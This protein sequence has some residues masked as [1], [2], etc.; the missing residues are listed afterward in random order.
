MKSAILTLVCCLFS[1][2]ASAAVNFKCAA[3]FEES[4]VVIG[5]SFWMMSGGEGTLTGDEAYDAQVKKLMGKLS[6][7][8][9]ES[10]IMSY[11]WESGR[12]YKLSNEA[13]RLKKQGVTGEAWMKDMVAFFEEPANGLCQK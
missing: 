9:D 3:S 5:A 8:A 10:R 12:G 11:I 6:N 1:L 13:D 4:T 2:N 7:D